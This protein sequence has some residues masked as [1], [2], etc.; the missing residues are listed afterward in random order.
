MD[1]LLITLPS[2][3]RS[4]ALE[5]RGAQSIL[6]PDRAP[7]P[8]GL[9]LLTRAAKELE[10]LVGQVEEWT[11][12]QRQLESDRRISATKASMTRV[13]RAASRRRR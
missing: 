3:L 12:A 13:T 8:A 10:D 6:S 7:S 4:A 1:D 9:A 2:R 5:I 11:A